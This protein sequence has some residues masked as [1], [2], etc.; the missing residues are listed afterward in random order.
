MQYIALLLSHPSLAGTDISG[1]IKSGE[2]LCQ[3][4]YYQLPNKGSPVQNAR[5]DPFLTANDKRFHTHSFVSKCFT[6]HKMAVQT[7]APSESALAM[8]PTFHQEGTCSFPG[9]CM[10]DLRWKQW[11]WDRPL[12]VVPASSPHSHTHSLIRPARYTASSRR[13][14]KNLRTA[15][16]V[17]TSPQFTDSNPIPLR[18]VVLLPSRLFLGLVSVFCFP[19]TNRYV[20]SVR[21]P[22]CIISGTD[23]VICSKGSKFPLA[24][25]RPYFHTSQGRKVNLTFHS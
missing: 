18:S 25:Y 1:T 5:S 23:R 4:W 11:Q 6:S 17:N 8:A 21:R 14:L 3:L 19:T 22:R 9:Q 7:G 12:C 15:Q 13:L 20:L 16:A 10:E 2:F 24:I